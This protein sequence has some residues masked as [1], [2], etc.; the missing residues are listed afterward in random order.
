MGKPVY[1]FVGYTPKDRKQIHDW[2]LKVQ[3][4]GYAG[5]VPK[6]ITP[7]PPEVNPILELAYYE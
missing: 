7:P 1:R 3:P 4:R 5:M 6:G 2:M